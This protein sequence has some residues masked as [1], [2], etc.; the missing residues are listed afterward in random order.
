MTTQPNISLP[1]SPAF[2]SM[3]LQ[4]RDKDVWDHVKGL[5]QVQADH[6]IIESHQVGQA[7]SALAEAMLAV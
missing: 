6:S 4:F 3:S 1:N 5:A 7:R 2:K